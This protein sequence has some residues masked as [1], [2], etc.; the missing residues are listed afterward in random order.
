MTKE[1]EIVCAPEQHEDLSVLIKLAA[2]SLNLQPQRISALKI[3]KRSI[4][5]RGRKVVYRMQVKVFID[6][7][8]QAEHYTVNY[9]NVNDAKPVIIV[10][11]GPAGLFAALQC[12]ELGIKPVIIERGKDVKQRRRDL[13]NINKEGLINPESNYCFGEGG[14][15]T[16]SD[17]KLYTRSTKRGDVNQVLKV[18]VAHGATEDILIDARPHIGTNKLPQIIA[19]MR[20]TILNAGG[21]IHFDKKVTGL[22]VSFNKIKGVELASGQ[23]INADAV[24]LATGHSAR[25]VFEMLHRQ[26]ILIEAKPFALGVRIEHPQEIIDRAQYHCEY[27]GPHLPPSYYSL[28]EQVDE[29]G[30]FSFCMCPGGIIAPCATAANEIVVNGWSP[31]K[32]NNPYANSGTVV[33]VNFEDVQGDNADPFK[34]LR[35]QQ[36]IEQ[37][38]FAAG[39]DNLVA[40]AQRMVDFVEGRLSGDLPENSYLPGTKSVQLKEVLPSW[41]NRRLQKALPAFGKKMK[42]YYTNE[43]ILVGVESRTSSPVKIPRDKETMQHPQI[44]GLYPCGEGAGYAGGIISA[45]IDGINCA[46]AASTIVQ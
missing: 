25:D 1:T 21:E 6:E 22:Q 9:P 24:I 38:A 16:Y 12:I 4:D 33:Q 17:G 40:P 29:R 19:A 26:N 42:G 13:A 37:A 44:A 43:A 8:H 39:G 23:K 36:Q 27:R 31:S 2:S 28:V 20:E 7:S 18:F 14:A 10:G 11:A 15:G 41:I 5:A 34:M 3:I 32:R 35:F 30:V 45:A 46:L